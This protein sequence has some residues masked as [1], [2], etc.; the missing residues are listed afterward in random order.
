M[1]REKFHCRCGAK[2]AQ[3]KRERAKWRVQAQAQTARR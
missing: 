3:R 1:E 2:E